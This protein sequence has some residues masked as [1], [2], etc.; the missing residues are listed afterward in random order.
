MKPPSNNYCINGLSLTLQK[1][2]SGAFFKLRLV[3]SHWWHAQ[4]ILTIVLCRLYLSVV[5]SSTSPTRSS[6]SQNEHVYRLKL[7]SSRTIFSLA[8]TKVPILNT[9]ITTARSALSLLSLP[10]PTLTR[11]TMTTLCL[12]QSHLTSQKLNLNATRT[13]R[14][15]SIVFA[16]KS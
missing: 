13:S 15:H 9:V 3:R 12:I 1:P 14:L 8:T 7:T 11:R 4:S 10:S 6:T 16:T 5:G 2:I